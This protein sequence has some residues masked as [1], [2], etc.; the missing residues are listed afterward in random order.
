[1]HKKNGIVF[2]SPNIFSQNSNAFPYLL[3][4]IIFVCLNNCVNKNKWT[5]VLPVRWISKSVSACAD[6]RACG[7]GTTLATRRDGDTR[8]VEEALNWTLPAAPPATTCQ[9]SVQQSLTSK[10][11]RYQLTSR[12]CVSS[13]NNW[14]IPINNPGTSWFNIIT[15]CNLWL[16]SEV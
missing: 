7:R 16:Q 5:L 4:Y 11:C 15:P 2:I 12:H 13:V 10:H 8:G 1:M 3:N 6:D 14:L 9:L